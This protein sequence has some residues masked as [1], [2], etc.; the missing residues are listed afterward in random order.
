[1]TTT[2]TRIDLREDLDIK[3]LAMAQLL[4]D[5][6]CFK[7]LMCT[8][9]RGMSVRDIAFTYFMPFATCYKKVAELKAAG[10]IKEEEKVV[11][12]NGKKSSVY[13]SCLEHF[14]VQYKSSRFSMDIDLLRDGPRSIELDLIDGNMVVTT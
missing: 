2:E 7:I 13:R 10:L 6:Y 3:E 8:T 1:M 11:Q 9:L 12:K 5:E 4:M 14:K